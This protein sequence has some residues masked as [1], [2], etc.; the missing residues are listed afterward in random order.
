MVL[1]LAFINLVY[2]YNDKGILS[3]VYIRGPIG[4][5]RVSSGI[6]SINHLLK[7]ICNGIFNLKVLIVALFMFPNS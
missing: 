1:F 5:T 4:F 2:R 3:L 7:Y 6:T